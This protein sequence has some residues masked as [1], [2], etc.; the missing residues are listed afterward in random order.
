MEPFVSFLSEFK[1]LLNKR[2][3][4]SLIGVS[5]SFCLLYYQSACVSSIWCW[6]CWLFSYYL[7]MQLYYQTALHVAAI[8]KPTINVLDN[9]DAVPCPFHWF[10]GVKPVTTLVLL[11]WMAHCSFL[12]M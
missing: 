10:S 3:I 8:A 6:A 7:F 1:R 11:V 9:G 2:G 4:G 5:M 12:C